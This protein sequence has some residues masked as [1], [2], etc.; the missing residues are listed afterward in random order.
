MSRLAA[1]GGDDGANDLPVSSVIRTKE[2]QVWFVSEHVVDTPV[3]RVDAEAAA[4]EV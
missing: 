4:A 2:L 1:Q 3:G